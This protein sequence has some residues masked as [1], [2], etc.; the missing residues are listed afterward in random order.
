MRVRA[1]PNALEQVLINLATNAIGAMP[2]GGTL[3]IGMCRLEDEG[4]PFAEFWVS[5]TGRGIPKD[6]RG[7]IFEPFFTTKEAGKG[8]GLG[9]AL[10][11]EIVRRHRGRIRC[12]SEEGKGTRFVVRLPAKIGPNGGGHG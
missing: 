8:T 11:F 5:D 12:E 10:A 2:A 3:T 1:E 9:L 7:R 6:I 4:R